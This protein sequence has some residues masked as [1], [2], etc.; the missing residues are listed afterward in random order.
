MAAK[1]DRNQQSPSLTE[2]GGCGGKE[3]G[4]KFGKHHLWAWG[5]TDHLLE[6]W[7]QLPN[8]FEE[9]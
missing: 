2:A 3:L 1:E 7:I 5:E 4:K 9:P 6:K 8:G